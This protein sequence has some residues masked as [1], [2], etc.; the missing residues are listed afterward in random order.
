[1]CGLERD[2]AT[3]RDG[4]RD[5][6]ERFIIGLARSRFGGDVCPLVH[7]TFHRR[8]E[9]DICRVIVEPADR[10]VYFHDAGT[11]RLFA[12]RPSGVLSA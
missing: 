7:V 9:R 1:M 3:L 6:F 5:G 12:N 8:D 10:P 4:N 11:S 2:Y